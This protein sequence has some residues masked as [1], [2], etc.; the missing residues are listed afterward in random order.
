MVITKNKKFKVLLFG[1]CLAILALTLCSC[2]SNTKIKFTDSEVKGLE[3]HDGYK[4][5]Q[6]TVLNRHHIRSTLS[7]HGSELDSISSHGWLSWYSKPGELS[8][9]GGAEVSMMGQYFRK[10]LESENFIPDNWIPQGDEVNFY[11]NSQQRTIASSHYFAAGLLPVVNVDVQHKFDIGEDDP[12]FWRNITKKSDAWKNQVLSEVK[13][14]AG[15]DDINQIL[16]NNESNFNALENAL[17]FKNSQYAKDN[18][19]S[20]FPLDDMQL[21]FE[22][23]KAPT[24]KGSLKLGNSGSDAVKLQ[25]YEHLNDNEQTWLNKISA[26]DFVKIGRI[27]D[28][29]QRTLF[30]PHTAAIDKANPMLKVMLEDI[31][32]KNRKF[33]YL[34]GHDDNIMSLLSALRVKDYDL[35]NSLNGRSPIGSCLVFSKWKN[36]A[37]EEF[38]RVELV[39]ASVD[40]LYKTEVLSMENPPCAYTLEFEDMQKNKDGFYNLKDIEDR[41][42]TAIAEYDKWE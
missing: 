31:Q 8:L 36:D 27:G 35:P 4:L 32:N 1:V 5:E 7:E 18:N 14:Y 2:A 22:Y 24:V 30:G 26:E 6:M 25:A 21:S 39:Y 38:C 12:V 23:D 34:G 29:Y 17:D 42:N 3:H 11:A 41:F 19:I 28:A 13:E 40:Q 10:Y 9:R 37:G 16:K 20:S 15:S 33:S